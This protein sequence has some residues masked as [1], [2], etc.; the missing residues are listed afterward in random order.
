[1][2]FKIDNNTY[3]LEMA[4]KWVKYPNS[5]FIIR[6]IALNYA[7]VTATIKDSPRSKPKNKNVMVIHRWAKSSR[8]DQKDPSRVTKVIRA[9]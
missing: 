8:I 2:G 1:M 4:S 6:K 3:H 5:Q 9:S 7:K